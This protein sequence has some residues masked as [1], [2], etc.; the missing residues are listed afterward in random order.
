MDWIGMVGYLPGPIL[1]A[2]DGIPVTRVSDVM[3]GR[4]TIRPVVCLFVCYIV[5]VPP[6]TQ[7]S[8]GLVKW[9]W[10]TWKRWT[11]TWWTWTSTCR[12]CPYSM[13]RIKHLPPPLLPAHIRT[14]PSPLWLGLFWGERKQCRYLFHRNIYILKGKN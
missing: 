13:F 2:P 11:R 7:A 6:Y 8:V 5:I 12:K 9:I 10:H 1:R 14:A 3:G 4:L